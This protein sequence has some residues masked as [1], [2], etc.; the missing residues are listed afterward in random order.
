MIL[1]LIDNNTFKFVALKITICDAAKSYK[2]NGIVKL[3]SNKRYFN[4]VTSI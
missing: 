1:F 3:I 4:L 2:L